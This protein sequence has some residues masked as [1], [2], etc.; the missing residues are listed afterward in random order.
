MRLAEFILRDMEAILETWDVFAATQL[1]AARYLDRRTLRDHAREIL[2][3]VAR[4][5]PQA[6]SREAQ[7]LKSEGLAPL[8]MDARDTAA[9]THALLRAQS[10]FDI[11]QMAAEYRAL[12][13]SVLR[14][15]RDACAGTGTDLEDTMRFN[16]AIDQA[17]CESIAFFSAE[18][19]Q[20]RNLF[21]GMLGHDMRNPLSSIQMTSAYLAR[22]NAGEEVSNAARR[23]INS[24]ARMEALLHDLT[25]FNRTKLG[26]GISVSRDHV[27]LGEIF[28]REVE[29]MQTVHPSHPLEF[30]CKGDVCGN[31]DGNR[32]RQV[33]GNLLANAVRYGADDGKVH[34]LLEGESDVVVLEVRNKGVAIEPETF[35]LM[36]EPLVRGEKDADKDEEAGLGL[37]LYI[38]REIARAHGGSIDAVSDEH[39]TLFRVRIPR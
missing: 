17:L 32:L 20:G 38:S 9:E 16:E 7:I 19:E 33:L 14:L 13:A 8:V 39:G 34:V 2:Q 28:A 6:Q 22:L 11:N 24:G 30:V 26:L 18:V 27:D 3:A 21:L 1:P 31:W 23:L 10:G 36:F 4:D 25:D 15:W 12:R 35:N 5:I 29:Q 37:G